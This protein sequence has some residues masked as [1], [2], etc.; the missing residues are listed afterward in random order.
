M[1]KVTREVGHEV[2]R[3]SQLVATHVP[4]SGLSAKRRWNV[5]AAATATG[6]FVAAFNLAA[7]SLRA[8]G[9]VAV[10]LHFVLSAL[11]KAEALSFDMQT[12]LVLTISGADRAGLVEQLAE[13][14][15]AR[16]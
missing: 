8:C 1:L 6:L 7:S 14:V 5:F 2:G 10:K 15:S 4:G 12:V 11:L 16:R 3:V 9:V 13:V